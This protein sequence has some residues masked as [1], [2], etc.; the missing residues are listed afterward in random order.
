MIVCW[1]DLFQTIH[2]TRTRGIAYAIG[3]TFLPP[4]AKDATK[5]C[6]KIAL[7]RMVNGNCRIENQRANVLRFQSHVSL[8]QDGAIRHGPKIHSL[9]AKSR[10]QISN[11]GGILFGRVSIN[12]TTLPSHIIKAATDKADKL[13]AAAI[14]APG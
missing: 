3:N 2:K 6:G 11:I 13:A 1:N 5:V 7:E 8:R 9:K 14:V 12:I 10:A 4:L